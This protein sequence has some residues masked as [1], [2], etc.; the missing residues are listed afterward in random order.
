[1]LMEVP[2]YWLMV[3]ARVIQG[4]S[5]SV[6]WVVGL[7]LL[8]DAFFIY[9]WVISLTFLITSCDTVP[10]ASVGSVYHFSP[11]ELRTLY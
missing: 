5:S 8:Y 9:V 4:I 7:A 10:E 2:T 6:V 3:I 11:S 1:M